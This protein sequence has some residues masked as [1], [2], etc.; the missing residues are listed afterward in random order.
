MFTQNIDPNYTEMI[1]IRRAALKR[2]ENARVRAEADKANAEKRLEEL[3]TEV[4]GLG[5][6]PENLEAEITR[7]DQEIR[8]GLQ[9]VADLIPDEYKR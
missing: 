8:E 2:M 3:N 7:L 6:E 4:K 5:V 1:Q 9:R